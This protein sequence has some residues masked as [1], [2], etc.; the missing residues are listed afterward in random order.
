[1]ETQLQH[2]K[3]TQHNKL[4]KLFQK[5]KELFNI[6][7][8][9]WKKDPVEFELKEDAKLLHSRLYPV[10]YLHEE[11]FKMVDECFSPLGVLLPENYSEWESPS[12]AQPKPKSNQ[13]RFLSDFRNLNKKIKRKPYP[14]PKT[15]EML[16]E[17]EGFQY[18]TSIDLNMG[19][20][21][22]KFSENTI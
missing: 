9:T 8:G 15:I 6:T 17:L 22:I 21:Q 19:Y 2:L 20:Y 1:M 12:F 4:L 13:V 16:L 11:N 7:L 5:F 14:I 18:A 10:P 3:E